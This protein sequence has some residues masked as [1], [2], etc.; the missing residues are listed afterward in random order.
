M[1]TYEDILNI[2]KAW[3]VRTEGGLAEKMSQ[4]Y[5]RGISESNAVDSGSV[6]K[7]IAHEVIVFGTVSKY[8]GPLM[9]LTELSNASMCHRL[10]CKRFGE[11]APITTGFIKEVH[12]TML[13]GCYDKRRYIDLE[14]RPGCFKK[15]D[16]VV[17]RDD[18]GVDPEDVEEELEFLL[19]EME[20]FMEE[21]DSYL[22]ILTAGAYFHAKFEC[23]HPF[24]DGNGRVGRLLLNY[25]LV[26][27]NHPPLT[28]FSEDK[29]R[30]FDA[31]QAY[32]DQEDLT[33]L[34]RFFEA[35]TIKTWQ[36]II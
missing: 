27:N 21:C 10:L 26:L 23:I 33:P 1:V 29:R 22:D 19:R 11:H 6:S 3:D 15:H 7:E 25:W 36:G 24:A 35:Q 16:F 31:L 28:V 17:G 30:Y 12:G 34:R 9:V 5:I 32:V 4:L 13:A 14:E 8:T 18:V 20:E 2:W